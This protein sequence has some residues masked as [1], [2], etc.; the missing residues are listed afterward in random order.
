MREEQG[1]TAFGD[2][3]HHELH[4]TAG[5]MRSIE[6][7]SPP[8]GNR[9]ECLCL[10]KQLTILP[11]P[12]PNSTSPINIFSCTTSTSSKSHRIPKIVLHTHF[13]SAAAENRIGAKP[14]TAYLKRLSRVPNVPVSRHNSTLTVCSRKAFPD[15]LDM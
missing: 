7:P 3:G 15:R 14:S 1:H 2:A 9:I 10:C 6:I 5:L 4:A 8:H 11:N 12:P 13:A